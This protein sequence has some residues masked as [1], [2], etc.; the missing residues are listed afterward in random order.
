MM[1]VIV[2]EMNYVTKKGY[3]STAAASRLHRGAGL[4][5]L[6]IIHIKVKGAD[7]T[8]SIPFSDSGSIDIKIV[9]TR[10]KKQ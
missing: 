8:H 4:S 6:T 9:Q 10:I 7:S 1:A 2:G 3:Q 5:R